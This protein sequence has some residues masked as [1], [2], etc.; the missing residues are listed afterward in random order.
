[1]TLFKINKRFYTIYTNVSVCTK[2]GDVRIISKH[3]QIWA[4]TGSVRSGKRA[5]QTVL[6]AVDD[7]L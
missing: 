6:C 1:M 4:S 3:C 2:S 5:V 7:F